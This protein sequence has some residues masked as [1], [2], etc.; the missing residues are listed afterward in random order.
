MDG[1]TS[2]GGNLEVP[3]ISAPDDKPVR[4]PLIS[5]DRILLNGEPV[6]ATPNTT[7]SKMYY[8]TKE[9]SVFKGKCSG[10]KHSETSTIDI[11]GIATPVP[12]VIIDVNYCGEVYFF[13]LREFFIRGKGLVDEFRPTSKGET[14]WGRI[15]IPLRESTLSL[16]PYAYGVIPRYTTTDDDER[17]EKPSAVYDKASTRVFPNANNIYMLGET[18]FKWIKVIE[19]NSKLR[20]ENYLDGYIRYYLTPACCQCISLDWVFNPLGPS[21][22]YWVKKASNGSIYVKKDPNDD[23]NWQKITVP[24]WQLP[25]DFY[26]PKSG[27][28]I[29]EFIH[30]GG[31]TFTGVTTDSGEQKQYGFYDFDKKT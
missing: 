9:L 3:S 17:I 24:D 12:K 2:M 31:I 14:G 19:E 29:E 20:Y 16:N 8:N 25:K 23:T 18:T 4:I 30:V 21:T 26:A 6:L 15:D 7:L 1:N 28:L 27:T 13:N 5:S 10:G 22:T 11:D